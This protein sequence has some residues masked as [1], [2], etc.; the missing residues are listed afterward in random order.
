M[1][2]F[3]D[4]FIGNLPNNIDLEEKRAIFSYVQYGTIRLLK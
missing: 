1:H 3:D 2:N 4:L